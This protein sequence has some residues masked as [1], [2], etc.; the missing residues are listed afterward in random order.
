MDVHAHVHA[1]QALVSCYIRGLI[2]TLFVFAVCVRQPDRTARVPEVSLQ[3]GFAVSTSTAGGAVWVASD[4]S[5]SSLVVHRVNAD[6]AA[7]LPLPVF[8]DRVIV[9]PAVP[10]DFN[11]YTTC[12]VAAAD[13]SAV[14][15]RELAA[16]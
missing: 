7:A 8:N 2:V 10:S 13:G 9:L 1:C 3:W 11:A 15:T 14:Y 6:Q 5:F 16:K 12:L 4:L